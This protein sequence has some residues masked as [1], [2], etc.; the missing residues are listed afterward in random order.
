MNCPYCSRE[1]KTGFIKTRGES[2][3]WTPEGERSPLTRWGIPA[4]G[5]RVGDYSYLGGGMV[6]A[7]YCDYCGKIIINV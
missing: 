1:M 7:D 3:T 4:N 2:L 6:Y 5:I